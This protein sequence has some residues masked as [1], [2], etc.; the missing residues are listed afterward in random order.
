MNRTTQSSYQRFFGPDDSS[1]PFSVA[2]LPTAV[3][4]STTAFTRLYHLAPN[5]HAP[6]PTS[7]TARTTV[8][9]VMRRFFC[10]GCERAGEVPGSGAIGR[11]VYPPAEAGTAAAGT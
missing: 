6:K 1:L 9:M 3:A 8:R 10:F 2:E 5:L 7:K 4:I 11:G